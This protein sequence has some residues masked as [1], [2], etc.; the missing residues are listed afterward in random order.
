M[1]RAIYGEV[2]LVQATKYGIWDERCS[3]DPPCPGL[4]QDLLDE[5][6][7]YSSG[8]GTKD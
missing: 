3:R 4:S 6:Y 1:A 7:R 2:A 5:R 8:Q